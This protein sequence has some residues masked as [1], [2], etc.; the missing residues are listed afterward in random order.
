MLSENFTMEDISEKKKK[1]AMC[2]RFD[3]GNIKT[4]RRVSSAI[5]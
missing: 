1:E 5:K 3:N 4:P 2:Q